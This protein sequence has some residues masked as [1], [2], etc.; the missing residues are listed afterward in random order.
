[1]SAQHFDVVVVGGGPA[2]LSAALVLGRMRRRVLLLDTESP[3]NAASDAM[4][5]FLSRDGTPPAEVRR[6]A[7]EQLRAYETIDYRQLAARAADCLPAGGFQVELEDGT[8]VTARR[9]L[10]AHGMRYG[11]PDLEGVAEFWGR[12][13]FHC[14]YCH[15]WEVRDQAIAVYGGGDRAVHQAL[16]LA[17][18]SND[19]VLLTDGDAELPAEQRE[20]LATA[21]IELVDSHV[22][23]I[24]EDGGKLR[25]VFTGRVPLARHALFI[26]P[27]LA[28][29]SDLA[30]SL[31]A[32]LTEV[33]S[34]ETDAA[35]QASVRGL[36]VAGDAGSIVQSVAVATGSGA[37]AA[38]AINVELA[39]DDTAASAVQTSA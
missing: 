26:Q 35:G 27:K 20:R 33:G 5:G 4:H 25:I 22:E 30:V 8:E 7:R 24:G 15:G 21:G 3:A 32:A 36:Y 1:M 39:M 13:V 37:R 31:G 10:L 12:H 14:P 16:L 18:L 9:L 19:V 34:V 23:R 11:L 6:A 28:L 38:Y 2:G 17:S 29:A